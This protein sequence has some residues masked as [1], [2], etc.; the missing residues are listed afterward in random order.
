VISP[1][2]RTNFVDNTITDQTSI[3]RFIEDNWSLG[4]IGNQ[5]FDA[6]AGTLDNM[7]DFTHGNTPKLFLDPV[8][9][10]KVKA[11]SKS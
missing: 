3:I 11:P 5:S 9:G 1:Y 6:L 10:E 8:T 4:R 2:A 7:F